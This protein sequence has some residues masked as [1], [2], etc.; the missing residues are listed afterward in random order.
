MVRSIAQHPGENSG[1]P[2]TTATAL[3]IAPAAAMST[4]PAR[5]K[6]PPNNVTGIHF[7]FGFMF[8][9]KIPFD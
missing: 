1:T 7:I 3:L 2:F 6:A 9:I 4:K 8:I 5:A